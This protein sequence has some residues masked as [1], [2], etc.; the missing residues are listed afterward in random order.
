MAVLTFSEALNQALWEEMQ[1]DPSVFLIGEDIAQ[2][3][4]AFKVTK[5]L[6]KEFG[7]K[8]VINTPISE[9]GIVGAGVGAALTGL[10][11]VCE[12]MYLDFITI[13]MDQIV[14]QAAKIRYML[15]GQAAVP[16][17]IRTQGGG[18]RG[19]AA[20][21]SQCLE[22]WLAHIPGL[23]VVQPSTPADAKGLLKTAIR[24]NNPVIFIEHKS[25]YTMNG[26][27]PEGEYTIPFGKA[28]IKKEGSDIT[29]VANSWMV[30]RALEAAEELEK[31]GISLEVIDL[32]TIM[33]LDKE[34]IVKSV[35]KTGKAIIVHEAVE[36]FGIGGE[37]TAIIQKEA[38]DYLE[39]PITRVAA[40][41][42]PVPFAAV[43]EKAYLPS[44]ERIVAAA[45]ELA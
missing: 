42:C 37:L 31:E 5:G 44:K 7:A 39:A 14:N 35:E 41:Y 4:G 6:Y 16:L 9:A 33:P 23:L 21:H 36:A 15:G 24:D 28:D 10:R 8:R 30:H 17:V 1:R 2:H 26:E 29:V 11:P 22:A 45:K 32:R 13:A 20:Q 3:E 34:T 18:G 38:F 12:L 40:P 43:L 25:L 19:N 27:V